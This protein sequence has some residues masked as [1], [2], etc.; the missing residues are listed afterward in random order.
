MAIPSGVF[1]KY[2]EVAD[3]ML[4][5][6]GFGTQCQLVYTDKIQ[7]IT[8]PVPNIKQKKV[9]N[10]QGI[11]PSSGFSFSSIQ[12]IVSSTPATSTINEVQSTNQPEAEEA[13]EGHDDSANHDPHFEPIIPLPELVEVKTGEEDEEVKFVHRSKVIYYFVVFT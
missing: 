10:L 13:D 2:A 11:S 9:M 6:S 1:T 5:L 7:V 8:D 12:S 4:S 3:T